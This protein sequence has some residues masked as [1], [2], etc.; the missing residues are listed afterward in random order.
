MKCI[1]QLVHIFF[2]GVTNKILTSSIPDHHGA[3]NL[4]EITFSFNQN[5]QNCFKSDINFQFGFLDPDSEIRSID[6]ADRTTQSGRNTFVISDDGTET[7]LPPSPPT[8][9]DYLN[10]DDFETPQEAWSEAEQMFFSSTH[11]Q[12]ILKPQV[13]RLASRANILTGNALKPDAELPRLKVV[14]PETGALASNHNYR[15]ITASSFTVVANS[16]FKI[17]E[18]KIDDLRNSVNDVA[19]LKKHVTGRNAWKDSS[20]DNF[21]NWLPQEIYPRRFNERDSLLDHPGEKTDVFYQH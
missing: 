6:E 3:S 12:T 7:P 5:E 15:D 2:V 9:I 21:F 1:S 4:S 18:E 13:T 20:H 19:K 17:Y 14:L 10:Y 16:L 8:I 11:R